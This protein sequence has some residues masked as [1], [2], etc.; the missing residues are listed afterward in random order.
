M[1]YIILPILDAKLIFTEE[2]LSTM[3]KSTDETEIIVHEEILLNKRKA[4]GMSVLPTDDNG[5]IQ[6][7]YPV[8]GYNTDELNNLLKSDK[9]TN[10]TE[11][12]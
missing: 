2:E 5:E 12:L 1:K 11:D 3:R 10:D 8:Y 9:W 6:W 7:T 4:M